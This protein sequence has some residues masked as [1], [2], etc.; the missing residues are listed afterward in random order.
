MN[1]LQGK[2]AIVTGGARGLGAA[3]CKMLVDEGANVI[4][5]DVREDEARRIAEALAGGP[6]RCVPE[7][8]DVLDD[9][10]IAS[11]IERARA[12]FGGLDILVNDAAVDYTLPVE[13][14]TPAQWDH[15]I[16]VNLRGPFVA[17][18]LAYTIMRG[19]GSGSIVNICSTA[20]KR[21]WPNASPYH[22]SKWGLLGFSHALHSEARQHG[23]KVTAIVTGGMRTPFLL[24]RF[25]D[26]DL[27]TLQDPANV[28]H[29]I[30]FALTQPEGCVIPELMVLPM[31]ETSWP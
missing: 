11:V 18:Q 27:T 5:G 16:G 6:G 7:R 8:L 4:C 25:P 13:E 12:E 30:R 31:R 14:L 24:E 17:S 29:A 15:E 19:Q 10:S 23:V 21:A 9:D 26:L 22:A 20:S 1:G 3:T 28:A 2:N